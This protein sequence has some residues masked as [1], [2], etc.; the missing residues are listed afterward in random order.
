MISIESLFLIGALLILFSVMV[1]R[2]FDNFG[3]PTVILFLIVGMIAGENGVGRLHFNDYHI[4]KSAGIAALVIILFSGGLDTVWKSVRP[5]AWSAVSLST[6]GVVITMCLTAVFT[7]Y[8]FGSTWTSGLLLGAVVSATDVAAVFSVLRSRHL[9]LRQD[10]RSLLELE[11]GSNDPMA[12]F[13][14]VAL[15]AFATGATHSLWHF[16]LLF[17]RQMILGV[18]FGIGLGK[19][20]ALLLNRIRFT[21]DGIYPVV[22]LAWAFLTYSLTDRLGGSGFL[23]VYLAGITAA[24][25]NLVH[26]RSL[27]RFFDGMAW[28]SQIGLFLVLG[29]LVTPAELPQVAYRGILISAFLIFAA[30]PAA[31]FCG[32]A[33]SKINWRERLFVS[34]VGLRGAAPIILATFPVLAGLPGSEKFFNVV[35]FIV[36][37]S[38]ALQGWTLPYVAKFLKVTVPPDPRPKSPL[39]FAPPAN[40]DTELPEFVLPF[41]SKVA[42]KAVIDL[43]LPEDALVVLLFRGEQFLVPGGGTVLE[44]QD[45]IQ[46]LVGKNGLAKVREIFSTIQ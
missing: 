19:L 31:V 21:Y 17:L 13:L 4:A 30:R 24:N 29:L 11:S 23:A 28:L 33:F 18:A 27:L 8:A 46:V 25:D 45:A 6:L 7:H 9:H 44:E 3:V 32:L 40:S 38:A 43:K 26:K 10:L 35:F 22:G 5:A 39:K 37:T 42:G 34:W 36:F 14:T 1:A 16:P 41:G 2:A 15:I 20:L 12:V